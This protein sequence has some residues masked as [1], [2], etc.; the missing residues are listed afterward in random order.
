MK[1]STQQIKLIDRLLRQEHLRT[2]HQIDCVQLIEATDSNK[3]II[4]GHLRN[5]KQLIE[6]L[7]EWLELHKNTLYEL[8]MP[9]GIPPMEALPNEQH[10]WSTRGEDMRKLQEETKSCKDAIKSEIQNN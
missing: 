2:V 5:Q 9:N 6:G 8:E 3:S 7:T 4:T 1:I 10:S